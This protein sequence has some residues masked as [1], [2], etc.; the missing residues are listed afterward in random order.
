MSAETT[1]ERTIPET[2]VKSKKSNVSFVASVKLT[3]ISLSL[4]AA[5]VLVGAWCP[6]EGQVGREKVF[7][8]FGEKAAPV[9]I[10]LVSR[11]SSTH[12]GFSF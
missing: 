9:L 10:Q 4:I 5:T 2:P 7:E 11:I 12:P 3:I 1:K 6:Q 8:A